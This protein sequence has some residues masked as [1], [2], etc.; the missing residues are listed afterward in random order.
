MPG[1][2]LI[3]QALENSGSSRRSARGSRPRSRRWA[4]AG[5]RSASRSPTSST[6]SAGGISSTWAGLGPRETHRHGTHRPAH[7]F[8][9]NVVVGIVTFI[10]DAILLPLAKLAE[11]TRGWPLLT[12]VLGKNPITG[13]PVPRN[14]E[15]LIGG[16]LK[17]I[18][19]G[20]D[21]GDDA[22]GQ[23]HPRAWAWFQG[24]MA[25]LVAFVSQIPTLA[26]N[27]F[28]SLELMDI[29][30]VPRAF[31]KIAGVFGGIHRRLH[32]LGRQGG[33][34]AA[35]DHLRRRQPRR[36]GLHQEDRRGAQEHPQEPAAVRRQPGQGRKARLPELRR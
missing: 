4:S 11:K 23:G 1:G 5:H 10:K 19:A 33:V 22:E 12:A 3:V 20:R 6:P 14:A 25:A 29:V 8:A 15:T 34:D 30:L 7:H 31:A 2:G 26:I 9:K 16:F 13:E 28:K 35:G 27:A 21:L 32:Q 24:A 17:L 36:D 18:G